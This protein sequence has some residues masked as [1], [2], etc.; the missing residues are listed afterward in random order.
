MNRGFTLIELL[1]G[2]FFINLILPLVLS[3]LMIMS[4]TKI[5][6]VSQRDVF[7]FQW[8]QWI[9]RNPV[10]VC[11]SNLI[12]TSQF[13]VIQDKTRLVKRPGYEIMLF[14]VKSVHFDCNSRILEVE[15]YDE[16]KKQYYW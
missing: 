10:M 6:T 3:M 12:Q 9:I 1:L 14:E 7:A 5:P 16:E 2:L 15:F 8:R 13:E 4:Q 11:E